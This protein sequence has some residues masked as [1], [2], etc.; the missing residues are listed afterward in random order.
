MPDAARR[1]AW[2]QMHACVLLWAFTAILGKLITLPAPQLVA[3]RLLLVVAMLALLP[4]AWRAV[5]AF[6]AALRWRYAGIGAVVALHWLAFYGSI[7]LANASVATICL[8]I[9]PATIA[10]L[11]PLLHGE[12]LRRGDLGL[13]LAVVPGIAMIGGGIPAGMGTGLLA[14]IVSALLAATYMLLNKRWIG[15]RDALGVSALEF[16]AGLALVL[17]LLPLLDGGEPTMPRLLGPLAWPA[18]RDFALL[19]LLAGACTL[20]PFALSLVALRQVSAFTMQL[21]VNLEPIYAI[22]MATAFL[23]EARELGAW[24]YAGAALVIGAVLWHGWR[25]ARPG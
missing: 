25:A 15:E 7:K 13:G 19:L 4:R 24:F 2:L 14:G 6:P 5:R 21:S 16:V 1:R 12:P 20:L 9:A 18:P 3:W 17:A 10:L 11:D 23:G 8:A 22:A